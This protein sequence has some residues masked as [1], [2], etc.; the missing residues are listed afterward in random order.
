ETHNNRGSALFALGRFHEAAASFRRAIAL[1]PDYILAHYNLGLTML[2]HG[3]FKNAWPEHEW[4]CLEPE[5]MAVCKDF[6]SPKWDGS[7]PRGKRILLYVEQGYGDT[8]QFVRYAPLL[9][10]RGARVLVG[11]RPAMQRLLQSVP[12]IDQI[13]LDGEPLPEFDLHC[14]LVSL[15]Y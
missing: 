6:A 9:H 3:D 2:L 11:C 1:K 4:R 13:I 7:D 12:G 8:I 14:S 15:P 10:E 5:V